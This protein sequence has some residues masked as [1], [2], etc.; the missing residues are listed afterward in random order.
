M[1]VPMEVQKK[2]V[3]YLKERSKVVARKK[4]VYTNLSV[5]KASRDCSAGMEGIA[6]LGRYG[7]VLRNLALETR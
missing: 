1:A 2:S 5:V 4:L 6:A 3:V 7:E